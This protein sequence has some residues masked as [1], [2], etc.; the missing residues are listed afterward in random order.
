MHYSLLVL[1][2]QQSYDKTLITAS[3]KVNSR[4]TRLP[5]LRPNCRW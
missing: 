3:T 4:S 1:S 5:K 2:I